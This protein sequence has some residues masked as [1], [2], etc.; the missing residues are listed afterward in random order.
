MSSDSIIFPEARYHFV[1][2]GGMGMAPLALFLKQAGCV[3][4]GEDD[5]FHPR[6][7][8]LLISNGIEISRQPDHAPRGALFSPMPS[9]RPIPLCNPVCPGKSLAFAGVNFWLDC[10]DTSKPWLWPDHMER[11]PPVA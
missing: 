5:N 7:Y 1:G 9:P 3:I 11:P 10:V 8:K 4:S 6:V 2:I